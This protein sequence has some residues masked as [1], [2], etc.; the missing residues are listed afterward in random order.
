MIHAEQGLG[1]TIQYAR[2]LSLVR[3]L[4]GE[5]TLQVQSSLVRLFSTLKGP[6]RVVGEGAE[7][8]GQDLVLP[9]MSLPHRLG[10]TLG[11]IPAAVPYLAAEPE[12]IVRWRNRLAPASGERSSASAGAAIRR[13]PSTAAAAC[14]TPASCSRWPHC[15]AFGWWR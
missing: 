14:R 2:F 12:R 1:D 10:L 11:S 6:T 15:R 7:V 13:R 9:M 5:V 8:P 3:S 4:G